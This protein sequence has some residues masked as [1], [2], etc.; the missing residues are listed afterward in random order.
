MTPRGRTALPLE[1]GVEKIQRVDAESSDFSVLPLVGTIPT[2]EHVCFSTE[3]SGRSRP[4][5]MKTWIASIV[6]PAFGPE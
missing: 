2:E 4:F 6:T 3:T 1:Y 5:A